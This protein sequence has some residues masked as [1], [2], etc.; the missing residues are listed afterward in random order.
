VS[1]IKAVKRGRPRGSQ[2]KN[3]VLLEYRSWL[4]EVDD[5]F[6]SVNFIVRKKGGTHYAYCGSLEAALRLIFFSLL[7]SNVNEKQDYGR[8]L[9]DLRSVIVQ[10]KNEFASLINADDV[11]KNS[12]KIIEKQTSSGESDSSC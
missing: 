3:I 10:T 6:P 12:Y 7:L 11:I 1:I 9:E 2:K 5:C 4:I 8:T